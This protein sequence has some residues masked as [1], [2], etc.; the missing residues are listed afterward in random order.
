MVGRRESIVLVVR[1]WHDDGGVRAVL[2][3]STTP[4]ETVY[5]SM[6]ALRHAVDEI[7]DPWQV[8]PSGDAYGRRLRRE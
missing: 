5:N 2:Q 4:E 7:L 6:A 3:A 1:M 8:D